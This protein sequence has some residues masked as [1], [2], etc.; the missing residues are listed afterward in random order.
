[1]PAAASIPNPA[2]G[3]AS[4]M[5][6]T[7]LPRVRRGWRVFLFYSSAVLLTGLVSLLFADLLWRTGWSLSGVVLLCLFI[8]LF[9]LIALGCMH[10]VFGFFL[11]LTDDQRLT[12]LADYRSRSI[13]GV[14]TALVFPIYN[15]EVARVYEGLR[16]TY[17]SLEKT[18]QLPGFDF[19]ILSDST[20]P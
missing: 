2:P 1:M 17:E 10:G 7:P 3:Q 9:F 14:S 18:G 8:I 16:A 12:R 11:R 19:Y 6:V 15:E 20:D 4:P 13:Q 5:V